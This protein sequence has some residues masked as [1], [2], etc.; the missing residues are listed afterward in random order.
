MKKTFLLSSGIFFLILTNALPQ[1]VKKPSFRR[2][3]IGIQLNPY[4]DENLFQRILMNTIVGVRYGYKLSEPL[5]L[6]AEASVYFPYFFNKTN[7][8]Y[9]Y[10]IRAGIFTRYSIPSGK[11]LQCFLE[12]SP[13][14]SHYFQEWKSS[15]DHSSL[16]S[17][18]L[19]LYAAPGVTLYSKSKKISFD[20]YYKF[21]NL[22][23]V[24]GNKSVLSYKVNYN[25]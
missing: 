6:G 11:R 9:F 20:L 7:L 22:P 14:L 8:P 10:S 18:K 2:N 15:D 4:L 3:Q 21:S 25:F 23:F 5:L 13:Y 17:N 16:S 19:G 1:E 24:N 12:V